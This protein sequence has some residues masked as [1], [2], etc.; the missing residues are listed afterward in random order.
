MPILGCRHFNGYKPCG[1]SAI[2]DSLCPQMSVPSSRI[3]IVHL[4]ALGAV[5]RSTALLPAIRR[6]FPGCH[7][8]WVT[9]KPAEQLLVNNPYIDRVLTTTQ[10]D[11]LQLSALEFD[12]ALMV[13]KGLKSAGV[14]KLTK[15]DAVFGFT[16]D[17]A[18]GV[19]VPATAAAGELW[20]IGL[21]NQKKFFENE[22][23]ETRLTHEALELG[24]WL[25]DEYVLRLTEDERN[26]AQARRAAWLGSGEWI[27][28]I[29]TGCSGAIPY[30]KLS[31]E[32]HRELVQ[33]LTAI[34]GV[35]IVLLGGR[36]DTL[37]NE[38]IGH[39]ISA[40]QSP[41]ERGLRDGIVSV[42]ACDIVVSGDSLGLHM[43]IALGK[44]SVAWFGPTCAQEIDLY[45][46]GV[47]VLTQAS[48]G[49]CWKRSCDRQPMCY[50]LVS[51][52][53]LVNAVLKGL[54]P[55]PQPRLGHDKS[56]EAAP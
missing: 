13:D 4:E 16:V 39:G 36:E 29:N 56:G 19:V 7:I 31:I 46:R 55:K 5:L 33:R 49:P 25:R 6:K 21:S 32:G 50:D 35:R 8:T 2:C 20:E 14:L 47:H 44:W 51:I 41:T 43:A 9:Q 3:L 38:R 30:K 28:G 48:C 53:Q 22:K 34:A 45:D 23:P 1:K 11:L 18:S 37:R 40:I 17:A 26:E 15:A 10:D 54:D 42:E 52:D 12:V 24:P 27:V